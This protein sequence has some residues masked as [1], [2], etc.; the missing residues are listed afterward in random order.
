[1]YTMQ[2][3]LNGLNLVLIIEP[4]KFVAKILKTV[5][6]SDK[7][8]ELHSSYLYKSWVRGAGMTKSALVPS[9]IANLNVHVA[10]RHS[11]FP[12][13]QCW[14]WQTRCLILVP[15]SHGR[16]PFNIQFRL[17]GSSNSSSA[18]RPMTTVRSCGRSWG[19]HGLV[20]LLFEFIAD[21]CIGRATVTSST[22]PKRLS[23]WN[24]RSNKLNRSSVA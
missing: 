18:Q 19:I 6:T 23:T 8:R 11:R 13:K 24:P 20:P 4:R 12:Y 7:Y 3:S 17:C 15:S 21:G 1:M 10:T 16:T 14:P 22:Q 5:E 2:E 9:S